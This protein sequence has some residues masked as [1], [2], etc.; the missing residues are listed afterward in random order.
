MADIY[1]LL[2]LHGRSFDLKCM[3]RFQLLSVFKFTLRAI[4]WWH[5]IIMITLKTLCSVA[6]NNAQ[7]SPPTLR[8][9]QMMAPLELKHVNI[10]I[11]NS[12]STSPGT[13]LG[14]NG[15][16]GSKKDFHLAECTLL[17]LPLANSFISMYF[18]LLSKGPNPLRTSTA[19][20][21]SE[22]PYQLIMQHVLHE[23]SWL[24]MVNGGCA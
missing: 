6:P 16:Y 14:S 8:Q 5:S 15:N 24:M 13:T 1:L 17:S 3:T 19:F 12:L 2:R 18:S 22:I 20:L 9:M 11:W 21:D 4:T 10:L 7:R 23:V